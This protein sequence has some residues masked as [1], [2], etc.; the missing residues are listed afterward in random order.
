MA[1]IYTAN[2]VWE[3]GDQV[4]VDKTYSRAFMM[5][6]DGG[7]SV[8]GSASP[9]VVKLPLSRADAVDPEEGFV[10]S[11]SSCHMLFFVDYASRAGFR[12]DRYDDAAEGEM[13]KNAE[14]RTFVAKVTLKPAITWSGD[15]K[16]TAAD[17]A[18][19]HHKSHAVC[20]IANS[21]KSEIVLADIPPQ[22][23]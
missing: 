11:I 4:F 20:F 6:F 7:I 3:R 19:L 18:D 23:A 16:P 9:E 1:H 14:G 10:A 2:I 22:F 21:V 17:I 15:K 13:G 5:H 8:P 12:V